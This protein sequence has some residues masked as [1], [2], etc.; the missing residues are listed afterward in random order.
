MSYWQ[1]IG[2]TK[3]IQVFTPNLKK[4]DRKFVVCW[5]SFVIPVWLMSSAGCAVGTALMCSGLYDMFDIPACMLC[6]ILWLIWY[7]WYYSLYDMFDIPACMI[8]LIFQL[9]WYVWYSGDMGGLQSSALDEFIF[10]LSHFST[11]GKHFIY[12]K[13]HWHRKQSSVTTFSP[14]LNTI[15]LNGPCLFLSGTFSGF[16]VC[17]S[18]VSLNV[19]APEQMN[20]INM[21]SFKKFYSLNMALNRL[22]IIC[23]YLRWLLVNKGII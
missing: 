19:T 18:H 1:P 9:V 8:C 15:G 11:Y 22:C 6:L 16:G 14:T 7:V 17:V 4:K 20:P 23:L 21:S 10:C 5:G 2:A 12:S 3:S 13:K